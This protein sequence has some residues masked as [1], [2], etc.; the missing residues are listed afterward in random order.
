MKPPA[1]PVRV[2]TLG[3][4]QLLK[5]KRQTGISN[6]NILC[7]WALCCS[8]REKTP[9]PR[10]VAGNDGGVEMT[11]KVF[12]GDQADTYAA[13]LYRRAIVDGFSDEPEG[14]GVCL[15]AHLHRGLGYLASE[16][17]NTGIAGFVER[18]LMNRRTDKAPRERG[19]G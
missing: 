5:L 1:D 15:R 4:D 19:G 9:P 13:L 11:W 6:W 8:M 16:V 2:S 18:W 12:A 7:R 17:G 10:T 14:A 3:R